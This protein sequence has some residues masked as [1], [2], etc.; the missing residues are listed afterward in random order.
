M[1][2]LAD[3]Q[4]LKRL[5]EQQERDSLILQKREK[6]CSIS[7]VN[8]TALSMNEQEYATEKILPLPAIEE[9]GKDSPIQHVRTNSLQHSIVREPTHK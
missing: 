8:S 5:I 4:A 1:K 6:N 9:K 2:E 7:N 3:I